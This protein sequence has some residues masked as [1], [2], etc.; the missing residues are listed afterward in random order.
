MTLDLLPNDQIDFDEFRMESDLASKCK[1]FDPLEI[2]TSE[3]LRN[4]MP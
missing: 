3:I 1:L 2:G 4:A